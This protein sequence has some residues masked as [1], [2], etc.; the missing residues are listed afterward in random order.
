MLIHSQEKANSGWKSLLVFSYF[1]NDNIGNLLELRGI[2]SIEAWASA[3]FFPGEGKNFSGEGR[4]EPTF[5]LKTTKSLAI[6]CFWPAREGQQWL[7]LHEN[8][9]QLFLGNIFNSNEQ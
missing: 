9:K 3:N 4:Q 1:Y 7:I 6:Y 8:A 5:C 2:I